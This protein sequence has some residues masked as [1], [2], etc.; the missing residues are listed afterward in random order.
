[1]FI[2]RRKRPR[3]DR[4]DRKDDRQERL[5]ARRDD[6]VKQWDARAGCFKWLAF[7][8]LM[9]VILV[10]GFKSG[11]WQSIISLFTK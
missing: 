10:Y 2:K 9:V 6:K 1:M 4:T 5:H 7:C 3:T 8:A 11:L